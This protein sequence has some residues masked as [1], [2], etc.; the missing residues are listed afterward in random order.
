MVVLVV[1]PLAPGGGL[2]PT[3]LNQY[4]TLKHQR[5]PIAL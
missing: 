3:L 1:T 5:R 4:E 2:A